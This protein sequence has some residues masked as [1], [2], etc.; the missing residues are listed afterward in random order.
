MPYN[1]P[2][3]AHNSQKS[4]LTAGVTAQ[5]MVK[6]G[7]GS[8]LPSC[9]HWHEATGDGRCQLNSTTDKGKP[10]Q[11][12][13]VLRKSY[14]VT[15]ESVSNQAFCLFNARK[16]KPSQLMV[17]APTY[18]ASL[19]EV[20]DAGTDPV[21]AVPYNPSQPCT[22]ATSHRQYVL[23]VSD[24]GSFSD[25]RYLAIAY[26]GHQRDDDVVRVCTVATGAWDGYWGAQTRC[27]WLGFDIIPQTATE[28]AMLPKE[29]TNATVNQLTVGQ[30]AAVR[31]IVCD[32]P[33]DIEQKVFYG[34][35]W[36]TRVPA[37]QQAGTFFN[38]ATPKGRL[39]VSETK[40]GQG[41][42]VRVGL[43][44]QTGRI[45]ISELLASNGDWSTTVSAI[46]VHVSVASTTAGV[47]HPFTLYPTSG[48]VAWATGDAT[49][50]SAVYLTWPTKDTDTECSIDS[51]FEV[52]LSASSRSAPGLVDYHLSTLKIHVWDDDRFGVLDWTALTLNTS[53]GAYGEVEIGNDV[54]KDVENAKWRG[55]ITTDAE[56]FLSFGAAVNN[57]MGS[58]LRRQCST[59][60]KQIGVMTPW[61]ESYE[62]YPPGKCKST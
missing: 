18:F 7:D 21:T 4:T 54:V 51:E 43:Q 26:S 37:W 48:K 62:R 61:D 28:T 53:T 6:T 33:G 56:Q 57:S 3:D 29:L 10:D 1:P 17:V 47:T 60:D 2:P 9:T 24:G 38:T 27:T 55:N 39:E 30:Q 25:G 59:S 44:S 41:F 40:A 19:E 23:N 15:I 34:E 5:F 20:E 46:E 42:G 16:S 22:T 58:V 50:P 12:F 52:T 14:S 8:T 11:Q 49:T 13:Q 35:N 32:G 36:A 45:E 31:A